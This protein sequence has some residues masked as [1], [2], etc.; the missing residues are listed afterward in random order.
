MSDRYDTTT[1]MSIDERRRV[2]LDE[3]AEI[4]PVLPGSLVTRTSRCG[5]AGCRCRADPPQL[6][7][8]YWVWT[9]SI[10]GKTVTR[11]LSDDQAETYQSWFDNTR[12]LRELA[13][14]LRLLGLEQAHNDT[15]GLPT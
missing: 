15:P 12:R 2:I 11:S 1:A 10:N 5:N 14:Q 3:I 9:R 6:H 13:D 4:G 8:P 7:G